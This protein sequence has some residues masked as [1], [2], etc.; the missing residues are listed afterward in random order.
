MDHNGNRHTMN[1]LLRILRHCW[2]DESDVRRAISADALARIGAQVANSERAHSGEFR[3]CIEAALPLGDLWRGATARKRAIAMF[4]TLRAWDT[5]HN[6]GVLIY[7]LFADRCIEIVA[8]RGLAQRV[9][10]STWRNIS[11][12]LGTAFK[13]GDYEHGLLGAVDQVGAVLAKHFPAAPTD[14]N[15][16][17]LPNE[18]D[19]R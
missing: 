17:E 10:A 8:D 16:N 1:K 12:G 11:D 6:N 15:P 18:P 4:S 7:L 13:A 3:V 9:P 14:P 19:V 2:I 5:E